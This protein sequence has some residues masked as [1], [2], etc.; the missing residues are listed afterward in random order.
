MEIIPPGHD[1]LHRTAKAQA[2]LAASAEQLTD[3]AA[4]QESSADR[5][6]VLA[7]DRTVLAAER[8]YA[9]WV[10]TGLAALAAGVGARTLLE[11]VVAAPLTMAT[12]SLLILFSGF[13]F[14]AAVWREVAPAIRPL[15][16]TRRLPAWL[17]IGINGFLVVVSL[18]ALVGIWLS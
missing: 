15:P 4:V 3:S 16:E 11:N 2:K 10:R 5:R 9:A 18:A 1:D 7:A 6:T 17:L 12:G 13:C 14:I 8:T